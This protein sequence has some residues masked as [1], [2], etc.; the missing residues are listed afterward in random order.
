MQLDDA[1]DVARVGLS[2]IG[3]H[4]VVDG[5]EFAS[6]LLDLLVRQPCEGVGGRVGRPRPLRAPVDER[7]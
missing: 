6:D 5:V 1:A 7:D 4:L 3:E 2:Q